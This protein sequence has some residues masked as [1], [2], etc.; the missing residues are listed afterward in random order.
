M[1]MIEATVPRPYSW[2]PVLIIVMTVATL[3]FGA[4]TFHYI[5]TRMV[6]TAGESLALIAAE[7]SDKLDRFLGE[8]HSDVRMIAGTFSGQPH[9]KEFQS[10]YLAR[11]KTLYSDYLWIGVTNARGEVVVA[12]DPFTVGRDYSAEPWFQAVRNGQGVHMGEMEPFAVMDGPDAIAMTAPITGPRGEFLGVV[13]TSVGITGLENVMTG[14]L[15]AFRERRGFWGALEYQFL[16]EKGVAFIDSDLQHKGHVN[17]QQLGLPSALLREEA[18]SGFVEEEHQHRHVPVISGYARTKGPGD[19]EGMHWRVLVR[20]DRQEALASIRGVLWS[21][22]LVGG[23]VMVPTFGLL[24]WTVNRVRKEHLLAKQECTL[25]REAE[26][27][28]RKRE[29]HTRRIIETA[30]DA[31]I[32]VD[33]DGV[34]IDWNVQAEQMFGWPRQEAIGQR[35]SDV[36]IPVQHQEA[37]KQGLRHFLASDEGL[38]LN[39]RFEMTGRHRDGHEILMELARSQ[40]SGQEGAYP[41]SAFVRDISMRKRTEARSTMQHSLTQVLAESDTITDAI[42]KILRITCDLSH[43]DLGA[44]WLVNDQSSAISCAEIWHQPSVDAV[45][46]SRVTRQDGLTHGLGLPGR[47]WATGQ[48]AWILDVM[49]DA[50]FPRARS[51]GQA[52]LHGAFAFPITINEKVLGV[53]EFF[54]HEIRPPDNDLLQV[55]VTVGNQ[56]AQFIERKR[57]EAKVHAYAKELEQNNRNLDT[58]LAEAQAATKAKSAFLAVMSHEIRT[59][60]NGIMGMIGLLLDTPMT[61]E[62]RDYAETVQQS[63]E[64]LLNIINDILDFSKI[65][66]GRLTLETIDFDL[67]T[68]VEEILD[69]FADTSQRKGLELGCLLHAEVPTALRGDPGRLRQILVNLIGNALKFT[70]QGEVMIHVTRREEAAERSLIE[71]AVIDTGIGIAP[72][73]QGLLFKPFTQADTSTTRKFGGTGLG[74]AICKQLVEQM[75][76]EIGIESVPGQGSAFRFT[77]WLTQQPLRAQMTV[78]PKGSLAGRRLCIVDDNATNRRILEQYAFQWGLQSATAS[79][80]YQALALLKD[81]AVRGEPFDLAI[82]DLQMPRMDGLEL[83]RTITADPVLAGTRLV[84]LT[85]MGIRGQAEKAKHAGISA[86]LSKPVHRSH[87]YDCLTMIVDLPAKSSMDPLEGGAASRPADVLV[88]RHVLKEAAVAAR[89][90]I[91]V[92]DDNIV[93]QKVAVCQLEKLGYRADIVANGLEAVDA[94]ARISY[95]LVLMDCQMPKM[96]GLDATAL[97]RKREREQASRRLPIIAMTADAMRGDREKCL[98]AGMDDYLAKPVKLDQ[99]ETALTRWLSDRSTPG[100]Q[101]EPVPPVRP[102]SV[103]ECVDAAVLAELRQLDSSCDLLSTLITDFLKDVPNYL[104][105]LRDALQQ[106]DGQALARVAHELNGCSGNLGVRSMR[107]LCIELQ[108][109]GRAK[110]LGKAETLLTQL[111]EEFE[112]VRQRLMAEHA[113]ITPNTLVDEE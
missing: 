25:V 33:A 29:A 103:Q 77:V 102:E 12:T 72:E 42:S 75:G 113:A 98:A 57:A 51:A 111:V 21:F 50:N 91:L 94:I 76:G 99:L 67:R 52:N 34:I 59:P 105:G 20:M 107:Q 22:A 69:L 106:G 27:L 108:A 79:D 90:R 5:E 4:T 3:A 32:E 68:T 65:E 85:S 89:A 112:L 100:E 82:L 45:E 71:F 86:Y 60:M 16:S 7:V 48:P 95:A 63:S 24:V 31:Y 23:A 39:R 73:I 18:L 61:P 87:L 9:N 10:A 28:L 37:H 26:V 43:W 64:A 62:Q 44:L 19:V 6:A 96:D 80:G 74:L 56:I 46:F 8:R 17:L 93:N 55:F 15:L 35:F 41:F 49:Q 66:S 47:V 11:M 53:M 70:Q 36:I 109:L 30:L 58:A 104:A 2:L 101:K 54:S 97:I 1:T 88:T 110:D 13:T 38:M 92:A 81:A 83:G 40:V 84:L 78:L 14:T